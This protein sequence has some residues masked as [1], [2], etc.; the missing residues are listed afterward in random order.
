[1][2][3]WDPSQVAPY[4]LYSLLL[5]TKLCR[6]LGC[7]VGRSPSLPFICCLLILLNYMSVVDICLKFLCSHFYFYF[8]QSVLECV[9]VLVTVHSFERLRPVQCS[10]KSYVIWLVHRGWFELT[11]IFFIIRI[12]W[13]PVSKY[14]L[15]IS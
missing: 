14:S 12:C 11:Q 4:S 1:M 10:E 9:L 3:I 15:S 7:H 2:E 6:E 5:L 13:C 8:L